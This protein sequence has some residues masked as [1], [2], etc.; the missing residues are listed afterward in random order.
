MLAACRSHVH[1]LIDSCRY[2][3]EKHLRLLDL[4]M[5]YF[6]PEDEYL[7]WGKLESVLSACLDLIVRGKIVDYY[8]D[9]VHTEDFQRVDVPDSDTNRWVSA[10]EAP[11]AVLVDPTTGLPKPRSFVPPWMMSSYSDL[12]LDDCL[13][14]WTH[15]VEAIHSRLEPDSRHTA[16]ELKA[17]YGLA[18]NATL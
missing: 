3:Q 14:T 16:R 7:P 12:D 6:D 18:D 13:N 5:Q 8:K 4:D 9:L 15:L 10:S 11:G 17:A 2:D 1:L